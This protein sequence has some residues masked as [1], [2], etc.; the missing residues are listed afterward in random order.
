MNFSDE[1]VSTA[2]KGLFC[3]FSAALNSQIHSTISL[4]ADVILLQ[5]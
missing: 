5:V 1:N 3:C 4:V 2:R